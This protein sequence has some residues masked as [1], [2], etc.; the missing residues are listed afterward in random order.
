MPKLQCIAKYVYTYL[1]QRAY[2]NYIACT[3][4]ALPVAT[5]RKQ[6]KCELGYTCMVFLVRRNQCHGL[7]CPQ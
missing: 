4:Y 6:K 1:Y 5:Q 2:N 7:P 3:K